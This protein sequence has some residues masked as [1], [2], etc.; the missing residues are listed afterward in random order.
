MPY[1]VGSP[2]DNPAEINEN[3]HVPSD[4]DELLKKRK[5]EQPQTAPREFS[6]AEQQE[7]REILEKVEK[8]GER[9]LSEKQRKLL[10][11]LRAAATGGGA[12]GGFQDFPSEEFKNTDLRDVA[13]E[14][15]NTKVTP[16]RLQEIGEMV[17]DRALLGTVS[18]EVARNFIE[19][20]NEIGRA[21]A[22]S[23]SLLEDENLTPEERTRRMRAK[24]DADAERRRERM[25]TPTS[26]Q[27]V[28]INIIKD[29]GED[30]WGDDGEYPL[31]NKEDGSINRR[32]F[33][34]WARERM[35]FH[36][37]NNSRDFQLQ[38]LREVGIANEFGS[39]IPITTMLENREQYFRDI[40][41]GEVLDE[42]A[43]QLTTEIWLF[44]TSRN[45]DL[46][47]QKYMGSD[48][49]LPKFLSQL[50]EKEEF[51]SGN[52][53]ERIM[54]MSDQYTAEKKDMKIGDVVRKTY[55]LYYNIS[56]YE[57]LQRL[58]GSDS[59][60]FKKETFEEAFRIIEGREKNG[61]ISAES[62][63]VIEKLFPGGKIKPDDFIKLMNPYNAKGKAGAEMALAREVIRITMAKKYGLNYGIDEDPNSTIDPKTQKKLASKRQLV[64][65]NLMYAELWGWTM[66]RWTG[67]GARNDT[68][69]IGFDAFTKTS[70][71]RD[72]RVRQAA[73]TRAASFGNQYDLPVFKAL[74]VDLLNG[75]TIEKRPGEKGNTTPFE[76]MGQMD[77]IENEGRRDNLSDDEI[78]ARKIDAAKRFRFE[79]YTQTSYTS[80][81]TNRSYEVFHSMMGAEE[82]KLEEIVKRDPFQGI[83]LDRGKFEEQIKEKFLKP[84]RYAFST[85]G[86]LD[87]GKDMR[88]QKG[89]NPDG[90]IRYVDETVAD[91]MFGPEVLNDIRP[92]AE[93]YW[94]AK[95]GKK[96]LT[97]ADKQEG[98]KAF[99]SDE[100]TNGG[101]SLL[102]KRASMARIAAQI[103]SH[104][105]YGNGYQ[106][107]N[108]EMVEKF[109]SALESIKA[110]EIDPDDSEETRMAI[111]RRFLTKD[112][113][114]WIRKHS[115]TGYKKMLLG[116]IAKGGLYGIGKGAWEGMNLFIQDIFK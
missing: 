53:F 46:L 59:D 7:L 66:A 1:P 28:A 23:Q 30:R 87:F 32:N 111:G 109:Y 80:D 78:T 60:F 31:I 94:K 54:T 86:Q 93:K 6:K 101:R 20:V 29:E 81:H 71:F 79:Q 92:L 116:E 19:K 75:I 105:E 3:F 88:V 106:Y 115:G 108:M 16:E 55:E 56:D 43:D 8:E 61:A 102:W 64:R 42:L 97:E 58:L 49:D 69:A 15:V 35:L 52:N 110:V 33:L 38:L 47:Y 85:Y 103:K 48:G 65:T 5:K 44:G 113:I 82:M 24:L 89:T 21:Q 25:S 13:E 10:I 62:Q 73:E 36:H 84:M 107:F 67:A 76:L 37:N 77:Q 74:T 22:E 26:I 2:M 98:W 100:T 70:K 34:I 95:T 12:G 4:E 96:K 27:E 63:K 57:E 17:R 90:T 83:I 68:G 45:N 41:T 50:H 99:L 72:Y 104:R 51:T 11:E 114:A 9:S 91:A 18:E 40:A 112:D 39:K 14:L